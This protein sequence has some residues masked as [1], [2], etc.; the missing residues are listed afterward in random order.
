MK[1]QRTIALPGPHLR[2]R[3]TPNNS[4]SSEF[5]VRYMETMQPSLEEFSAQVHVIGCGSVTAAAA[6]MRLAKS[7]VSKRIASLET[8]LG[9]KLLHRANR[10]I[11]PTDDGLLVYER[12]AALLPQVDALVDEVACRSGALRGPIRLAGPLSFGIRHLSRIVVDFMHLHPEIEV[13][14]DLDDRYVDLAGGGYDLALRIGRLEDSALKVRRIASSNRA[15]YYSGAYAQTSELPVTLADLAGHKCLG[16]VNAA[17]GH[18]WRFQPIGGGGARSLTLPARFLTNNGEALVD[19]AIAGLG[20]AVLPTFLAQDAVRAGKLVEVTLP[21]WTVEAD[22]IYAV[23]AET[24]AL[25]MRV[26][27]LIEFLATKL[28]P[29]SPWDA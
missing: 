12:A 3:I 18:I 7:V 9:A 4:L 10:R 27:E 26:R 8:C 19:A 16:Y 20:L 14:L 2:S 17:S 24:I 25:P 1:M 29:P 6:R 22:T 11:V 13:R 15:I 28:R 5:T 21:G 23:Y